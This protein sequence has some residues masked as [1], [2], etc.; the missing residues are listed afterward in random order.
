MRL[1]ARPI[2]P[3]ASA[4]HPALTRPSAARELSHAAKQDGQR[5]N[6]DQ[7]QRGWVLERA[8]GTPAAAD[9]LGERLDSQARRY[10]PDRSLRYGDHG[11][12]HGDRDEPLLAGRLG[13][14]QRRRSV[15]GNHEAPPDGIEGLTGRPG[16]AQGRQ[17]GEGDETEDGGLA[18]ESP[19]GSLVPDEDAGYRKRRQPDEHPP[20]CRRVAA[21]D[22]QGDGNRE[23]QRRER[24]RDGHAAPALIA[25]PGRAGLGLRG[26]LCLG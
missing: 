3:A 25:C 10:E 19:S 23:D 4:A 7:R 16:G 5:A 14:Q 17:G 8:T 24:P 11:D 13:G 22:R 15:G 12:R 26:L 18:D 20:R 1:S 9:P 2:A 6:L 21:A